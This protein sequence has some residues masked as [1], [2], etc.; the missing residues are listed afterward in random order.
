MLRRLSRL[1]ITGSPRA[2]SPA[3][4]PPPH[5][6][7]TLEE[8]RAMLDPRWHPTK[9]WDGSP[10]LTSGSR[11]VT[12]SRRRSQDPAPKRPAVDPEK[13]VS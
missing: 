7:P 12:P 11:V 9:Q 1:L 4:T 3:P 8:M 13:G 2:P 6:F 10:A 5:T